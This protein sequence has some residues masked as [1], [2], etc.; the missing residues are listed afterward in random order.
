VIAAFVAQ[1]RCPC[2]AWSGLASAP[3]YAEAEQRVSSQLL[4]HIVA[5][6]PDASHAPT[7]S[8]PGAGATPAP[9]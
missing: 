6:H 1:L 4:E 3:S 2:C 7:A 5:A 9:R 8:T